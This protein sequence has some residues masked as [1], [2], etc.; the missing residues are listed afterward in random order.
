[1]WHQG[2]TSL[3]LGKRTKLKGTNEGCSKE[4]YASVQEKEMAVEGNLLD[5]EAQLEER[6]KSEGGEGASGPAG[7]KNLIRVDEVES[8]RIAMV[9]GLH[10][11]ISPRIMFL[12]L[13]PSSSGAFLH[14]SVLYG[15]TAHELS[16]RIV[17]STHLS[18]WWHFLRLL[19][20]RTQE[21]F[22]AEIYKRILILKF[23]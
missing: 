22:I 20:N 18:L 6:A 1:M 7:L 10:G 5:L 8:V 3:E 12:L 2:Q 17:L 21:P 15:N 23:C 13:S 19:F 9:G 14:L 16:P 4:K 11:A